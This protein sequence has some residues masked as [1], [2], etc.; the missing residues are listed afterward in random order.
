M[1]QDIDLL[2]FNSPGKLTN[3]YIIKNFPELYELIKDNPGRTLAEKLYIYFNKLT[4][5]PLCDNCGQKYKQFRSISKGYRPYC[6]NHCSVTDK[7]R[8][9]KAKKTMIE[10]Y[11]VEYAA[12]SDIFIKKAKQTNLARHG[13]T[14]FESKELMERTKQ[15]NLERYGVE[16][17]G[18]SE[19]IK[20]KR[21]QTNLERY[22]VECPLQSEEIKEKTKQTNLE[23][24]GVEYSSQ[25]EEIKEKRKQTCL[26]KYGETHA[27]KSP[28]I[29]EK[30]KKTNL[31]RYGVDNPQKSKEIQEKTKRTNLERYGV[32]F[33]MQD[34]QISLLN[35]KSRLKYIIDSHEF[36]N[37]ID[38]NGNWICK[39]PHDKKFTDNNKT[40]KNCNGT[41]IINS[42]QYYGRR[43]FN[44]EPCTNIL[45]ID[46]FRGS[47]TSLELFIRSILD[48]HKIN[49]DVNDR[50][51]LN[52]KE[53]DL[54]IPDHKLAIEC[55]GVFWH[56]QKDSK[57]HYEKWKQC[58]DQDI[59]LLTIWEDWIK[60][61]PEIVRNIILSKLG[62]Y[63]RSIGARECQIREVPINDTLVFL[64]QNHIQGICHPSI[65]FG[66]YY[67]DEL[68]SIMCFSRRSGLSGSK[69]IN[70]NEY[71]LTRFCTKL[72]THITAGATRL[73]NYFIKKYNPKI[74]TSFSCND[75]SNG[76]LYQKLGFIQESISISYWYVAKNTYERFHRSRFTKTEIIRNGLLPEEFR[77]KK[78]T[79]SEVTKSMGLFKIFDSGKIKWTHN[80]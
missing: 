18:Q 71:E 39:C 24:Y 79:E 11:G 73:L 43:E 47:S 6:C 63:E 32:E 9:E 12:Q 37:D 38:E 56:S 5:I 55:N 29:K 70:K 49:Y 61:K 2:F 67:N 1:K 42:S 20:E 4:E 31:E 13:G 40:C 44:Y 51:I 36:I 66:L 3:K 25:S 19:E 35:K 7:V 54:Y 62:I 26:E 34:E 33:V 23:R 28:K 22:G 46:K 77:D 15:T 17:T 75:I 48:D 16:W 74:I 41:Y 45:P 53:L 58:N 30:I 76:N 10:K 27:T 59:Q 60:T 50:T 14:G 57:Y 8:L 64:E 78:W 72:N 69:V 68:V 52:G 80:F 21:K 65:H